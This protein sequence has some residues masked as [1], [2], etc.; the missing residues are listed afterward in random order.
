M[1]S[2]LWRRD[3]VEYR[4]NTPIGMR[5][6]RLP[7]AEELVIDGVK[8]GVPYEVPSAAYWAM[9]GTLAEE[10]GDCAPR[11]AGATL[12]EQ[13]AYCLLGGYG[14]P[15]EMGQSAF[16]RLR[17]RSM[18]HRCTA[19][20]E[21]E[22]ALT[23]P[24]QVQGRAVR[25]RFPRQKARYLAAG[26][27]AFPLIDPKGPME[28]RNLLLGFP[29]VGYKTAS[30]IVRDWYAA[31]T[32]AILDV[33]IIAACRDLGVFNV[34]HNPGRHYLE[35]EQRFLRF[36]SGIGVRASVLDNLMWREVRSSGFEGLVALV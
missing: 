33:H 24:M 22:R 4:W 28:A 11:P 36:A 26:L 35:M 31:D 23:E 1:L 12:V 8:W 15:A 16:E 29:G 20:D 5:S 2:P 27:R 6:L 21:I 34:G 10:I 17:Q 7:P 18:L 3:V 13:Y 19:A 9:E 30:W 14:M 25:Y 32:V